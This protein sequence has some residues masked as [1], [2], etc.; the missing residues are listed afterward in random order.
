MTFQSLI[1]RVFPTHFANEFT[2]HRLSLWF[3]YALTV[4]TLWRSQHHLFTADG[5]AQS[6]ASIP[7]DSFSTSAGATVV[8][9]FAL[10]GLSQLI[11]GLIYLVVC[12]RYRSMIPLMLL[13]GAFEYLMRLVYVGVFK[14]IETVETA[15]GVLMNLPL[16]IILL[17][18]FFLSVQR[19]E[20]VQT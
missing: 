18:M 4:L 6:I 13:L 1:T 17:L 11:V 5:G 7:L 10:W 15:P 19:T 20:S 2:G 8:S 3:F 9:V 12:F 16:L 14:P